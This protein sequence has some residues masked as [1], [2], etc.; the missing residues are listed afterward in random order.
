[1]R[2]VLLLLCS[3]LVACAGDPPPERIAV[4]GAVR[5]CVDNPNHTWCRDDE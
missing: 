4:P 3:L 1:M 5:F 2:L